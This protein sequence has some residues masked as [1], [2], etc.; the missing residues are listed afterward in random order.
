[1]SNAEKLAGVKMMK[2]RGL[3]YFLALYPDDI[4]TQNRREE[5]AALARELFPVSAKALVWEFFDG[6]WIA[7]PYTID[8]NRWH[9]RDE[10]THITPTADGFFIDIKAQKSACESHHQAKFKEL[11]A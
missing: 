11:L 3:L 9:Y 6:C 2:L 5:A 7:G 1:M 10:E 4:E 8:K